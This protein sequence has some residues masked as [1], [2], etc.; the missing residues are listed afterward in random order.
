VQLIATKMSSSNDFV[1]VINWSLW[2]NQS[3]NPSEKIYAVL[4]VLKISYEGRHLQVGV[5]LGQ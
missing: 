3:L 4:K 5:L 2:H 1:D